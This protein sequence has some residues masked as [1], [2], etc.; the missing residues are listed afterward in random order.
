MV[1][2][3]S[4]ISRWKRKQRRQQTRLFLAFKPFFHPNTKANTAFDFIRRPISST[5]YLEV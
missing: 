2:M 1:G 3:L 5:T 4:W